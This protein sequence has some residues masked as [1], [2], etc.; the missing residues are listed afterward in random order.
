M[1]RGPLTPADIS[2]PSPGTDPGVT[3]EPLLLRDRRGEALAALGSAQAE[4]ANT[5]HRVSAAVN[6]W[7]NR[8][9]SAEDGVFL[10]KYQLEMTKQGTAM[11]AEAADNPSP[12]P[13]FIAA[14]DAKKA[15]LGLKI[16]A[17]L[18]AQ[19]YSL[20][21]DGDK[22]WQQLDY[23]M[24]TTTAR[25]MAV[26][27]N[28]ARVVKIMDTTNSNITDIATT[29]GQTGDYD[30]GIK[31]V[32]QS[33]DLVQDAI[34]FEK[35]D[36]Y[37]KA[38]E[39][40]VAQRVVL[41][42]LDRGDLKGARSLVDRLS[43]SAP[44]ATPEAVPGMVEKGN[45]DPFDRPLLFNAD[46]THSTTRSF[47]IGV[48]GKEV[49]IPRVYDG[50][51]HTEAQ[52]VA[53]YRATGQHL[54]V[55]DTPEDADAYAV[56]LHNQQEAL[57]SG[58]NKPGV[59]GVII[60]R[61]KAH[62]NDPLVVAGISWLESKF[63]PMAKNDKSSAA[64]LG[65]FIS[66]TGQ[67]YGLPADARAASPLQ[68][69]DALSRFVADNTQALRQKLGAEPTPGEI[70][71]AHFLG[72]DGAVNALTVDDIT[73]LR[74]L[75]P[76]KV[77]A[78]NP[79][80]Q[81]WNA[82]DLKTWASTKMQGAME[83]VTEAGFID[84]RK[85]AGNAA[86]IPIDKTMELSR[87]V[88]RA[89]YRQATAQAAQL[90]RWGDMLDPAKPRKEIDPAEVVAEQNPQV[91]QA[92]AAAQAAIN[93]ADA[94]PATVTKAYGSAIDASLEAQK[95]MGVPEERRKALPV[96]IAKSTVQGLIE[97]PPAQAKDSFYQLK[98]VAG[99]HWPMVFHEL[100]EQALPEPW[101]LLELMNPQTDA[102]EVNAVVQGL[103]QKEGDLAKDLPEEDVKSIK[104][105][106]EAALVPFA[107]N[108][109][110]G[111]GPDAGEQTRAYVQAAKNAALVNYRQFRDVNKA[112]ALGAGVINNHVRTVSAENVHAVVPQEFSN[113]SDADI[114]DAAAAAQIKPEIAKFNPEPINFGGNDPEFSK[115]RTIDA[116][117][118]G[119]WRTN[120]AGD[121]IN[122]M[123]T[124]ANGTAAQP[125]F[126]RGPKGEKIY[127]E[128]KFS[129]IANKARDYRVSRQ[130]EAD[131]PRYAGY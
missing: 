90:K 31:R 130:P 77:L 33:I 22:R 11:D 8:R 36:A 71:L 62:G 98:Q 94:D 56:K 78:A 3:A 129:D 38:A 118:K 26:A 114:E 4:F 20:S 109:E 101:H 89:E 124:F 83:Y 41:G 127:Y 17:D 19:G 59:A 39:L 50:Q 103:N 95:S 46:G 12:D 18:Q 25:E 69:A 42:Y 24:R 60:D 115:T 48:N 110:I 125:L 61:A 122:L 74:K 40:E 63:N 104:E 76:A 87:M 102:P 92:A 100:V 106:V 84:G 128:I 51:D 97:Q 67:R 43:G 54:G 117:S 96:S 116:A 108:W 37:R 91:Q 72:V 64:G 81:S 30:G 123:V 119:Y 32:H 73:P 79:Q 52:A 28:N 34:P 2:R 14:H 35:R 93:S 99:D 120:E 126:R 85:V 27:Q 121:G 1:A 45:I 47:S 5:L 75:L 68:Q 113:V 107:Q 55:F 53:H 57:I 105:G 70:Y 65:Q 66:E 88:S 23:N 7:S 82:G 16:K 6:E 112:V 44:L 80:L 111:R 131:M 15:E 21:P 58:G 86:A 49:L 29:A 13:N 10:D 9:K